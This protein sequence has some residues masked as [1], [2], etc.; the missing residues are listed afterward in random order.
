MT[1]DLLWLGFVT[2]NYIRETGDLSVLDDAAPF[3]DEPAP[4]PLADARPR[5]LSRAS[6]SAR[7]RAASR[8]SAP[9]TGTTASPPM[10]LEER[11]ESVWLGALPRRPAR[12][13]GRRSATRAGPRTA[14][15]ATSTSAASAL[16]AA[17]N[18]HGWDGEW[19]RRGTLD[20]GACSAAARIASA[21]SS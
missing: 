10:G 7:A 4:A 14:S 17:I 16:V 15:R 11:G 3:L 18:E 1:D 6:S 13:T 9:A 21:G 19:Y 8:S 12:A 20:D 2:A 5:A